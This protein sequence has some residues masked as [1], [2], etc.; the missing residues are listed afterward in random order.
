[1]QIT[2]SVKI[3]FPLPN[4]NSL[5][6]SMEKQSNN[7]GTDHLI[8]LV[9]KKNRTLENLCHLPNIMSHFEKRKLLKSIPNL[10]MLIQF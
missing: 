3:L 1:M 6:E 8:S 5:A 2:S 4:L 10:L 9:G 7:E